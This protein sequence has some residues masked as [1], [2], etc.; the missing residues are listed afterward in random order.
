MRQKIVSYKF[1]TIKKL[2]AVHPLQNSIAWIQ[3]LDYTHKSFLILLALGLWTNISFISLKCTCIIVF[4]SRKNL[5]SLIERV[6][7]NTQV[8]S[9]SPSF[10]WIQPLGHTQKFFLF[11]LALG[12]WTKHCSNNKWCKSKMFS[13]TMIATMTVI[14]YNY[15][16]HFALIDI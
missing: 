7:N 16:W 12:L 6:P 5:T 1:P 9:P 11:L 14:I 10:A 4:F 15:I 3:P 13:N 8:P 2:N